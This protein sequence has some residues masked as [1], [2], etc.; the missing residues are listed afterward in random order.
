MPRLFLS[1]NCSCHESE[2]GNA[3]PG[4]AVLAALPALTM[5]DGEH[6][7]AAMVTQ[8]PSSPAACL[9]ACPPAGPPCLPLPSWKVA[10]GHSN[11]E[12]LPAGRQA[13]R[14]R[15]ARTAFLCLPLCRACTSWSSAHN[16]PAQ[17]TQTP[18]P[19][20]FTL[21]VTAVAPGSARR[22]RP[23][24]GPPPP[25][26]SPRAGSRRSTPPWRWLARPSS[27]WCVAAVTQRP[28]RPCP[29]PPPSPTK[30]EGVVRGRVSPCPPALSHLLGFMAQALDTLSVI[31]SPSW[32]RPVSAPFPFMCAG[33]VA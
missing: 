25:R 27:V 22:R 28:L 10:G 1:R 5:L 16:C 20:R 17:L 9:P 29:P 24:A 11:A 12:R 15:P 21:C 26:P 30:G 32:P 8:Q 18:R 4:L 23:T 13:G 3:R 19:P 6:V 33:C 31:D 7:T 2:D 14:L